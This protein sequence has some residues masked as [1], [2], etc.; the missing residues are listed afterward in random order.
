MQAQGELLACPSA[1][2]IDKIHFCLLE[3]SDFERVQRIK[4]RN[5]GEA[6]QNMLNWASWLRMHHQDPQWMQHV[7]IED[8]WECLD[9][10]RWKDLENWDFLAK[11]NILDTT[12]CSIDQAASLCGRMVM[13]MPI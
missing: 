12:N 13:L 5:S 1:K 10:S 3:V 11:V 4:E 9:F 2:K 7:I 6:D 8:N